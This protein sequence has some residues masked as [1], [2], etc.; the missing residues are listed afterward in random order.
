M[1]RVVLAAVL[2]AALPCADAYASYVTL[3]PNGA[4]VGRKGVFAAIGHKDP[5]GGGVSNVYGIAFA[6]AGHMWSKV[7]SVLPRGRLTHRAALC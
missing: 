3:N 1:P 5:G 7:R 6:G 4:N 2:A